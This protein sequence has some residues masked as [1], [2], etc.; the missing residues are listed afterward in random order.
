MTNPESSDLTGYEV[1][2]AVCGGIAAYKVCHVVSALVQCGAGVTVAMTAAGTRFVG[3]MTFQALSAR[4]VL[5]SLWSGADA[6]DPQHI[7][8]TTKADL[9][10]IA[11]ATANMIGKIAGGVCDDLVSTMVAAARCPVMLA[12]AMNDTMWAHGPIQANVEKLKEMGYMLIGPVSGWLACRSVGT[13]RLAEPQE[14][15]GAVVKKLISSP[16]K[17]DLAGK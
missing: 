17:N 10:L 16:P 4:Q 12:P 11:P 13:G 5:T 15:I 7:R 6:Y 14:I 9:F 2:V 1:I 8:L 3:T